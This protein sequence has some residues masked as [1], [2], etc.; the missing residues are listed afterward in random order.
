VITFIR[1]AQNR[2]VGKPNNLILFIS[3]PAPQPPPVGKLHNDNVI[4][5]SVRVIGI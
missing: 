5:D 1:Y 4:T 3:A 2:N